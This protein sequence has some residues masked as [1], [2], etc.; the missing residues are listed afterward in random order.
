MGGAEEAV[1]PSSAAFLGPSQEAE[2]PGLEP[3]P[4]WDAVSQADT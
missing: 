1:G 3:A 4:V 2:Q